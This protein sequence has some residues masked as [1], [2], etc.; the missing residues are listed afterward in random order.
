MYVYDNGSDTLIKNFDL[1]EK[2][3]SSIPENLDSLM[4][5]RRYMLDPGS[6]FL[7]SL[8]F[9][10]DS[11]GSMV[12]SFNRN[13]DEMYKKHLSYRD[14]KE[15]EHLIS[16]LK[17][18][19]HNIS[20]QVSSGRTIVTYYTGTLKNDTLDLHLR[21]IINGYEIE[22]NNSYTFRKYVLLNDTV[23]KK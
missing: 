11:S 19:N 18:L 8:M 1:F 2:L 7:E 16:N 22:L 14:I 6:T 12:L 10:P 15:V 3:A 9:F 20:F 17:Y 21:R 13:Y 23:V 5:N 4:P